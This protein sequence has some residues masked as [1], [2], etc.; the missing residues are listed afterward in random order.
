MTQTLPGGTLP[1]DIWLE[2]CTHTLLSV[3]IN[4]LQT[5][6]ISALATGVDVRPSAAIH[7]LLSQVGRV[8]SFSLSLSF[9]FTVKTA[10]AGALVECQ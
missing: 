6:A 3:S 9:P 5:I 4:G 7:F 10:V 1:H 2:K 8:L